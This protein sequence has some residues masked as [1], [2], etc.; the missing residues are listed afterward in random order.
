MRR[1]EFIALPALDR[2]GFL[3]GA[4]ATLSGGRGA[5]GSRVPGLLLHWNAAP[6]TKDKSSFIEW[7]QAKPGRG[8]DVSRHALGSSPAGPRP[9]HLGEAQYPRLPDDPARGVHS[10]L[11]SQPRLRGHLHQHRLGGDDHRSARG[12]AHDQRDGRADG[13]Q[14]ARDRHRSGY[15]SAY[16]SHLTDKIWS[17]EIIKP[18]ADRTRRL[19]DALIERG[20]TEYQAITTK[21]ADGYYGWEQEAPFDASSSPA[22]STTSR[23]R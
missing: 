4:G 23:R 16:L 10:R 7:M 6:P 14:G 21:H 5:G 20:Y 8:A 11:L 3:L 2:R 15:Q 9:R 12:R 13:R 1:R 19:Y 22:A 18:L 17:V